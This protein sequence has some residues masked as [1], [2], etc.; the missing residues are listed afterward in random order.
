MSR[1]LWLLIPAAFLLAVLLEP[2]DDSV[3]VETV[4]TTSTTSTVPSTTT[5]VATTTT[6]YHPPTT[7][8]VARSAPI[9]RAAPT[10]PNR[11]YGDAWTRLVQCEAGG[12]WDIY[13]PP[14]EGGPQFHF[15]TWDAY[16]D[17]DMPASANLATPA[18]QIVVA[19]R[20]LRAQGVRAWPT[21][22]PR[23]GLTMED[24]Q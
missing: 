15:A 2:D 20:V 7:A 14:H 6:H 8:P 19:K 24:A 1:L 3:R 12:R 5:S 10:E 13:N 9:V 23:V 21:C 16:R 18:Q 22:G 11:T 4:A 17:A